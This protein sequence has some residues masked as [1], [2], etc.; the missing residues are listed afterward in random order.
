ML[1]PCHTLC[2]K[3]M[4]AVCG[5]PRAQ[6]VLPQRQIY[7]PL[8]LA[9]PSFGFVCLHGL[10]Y[11]TGEKLTT[12]QLTTGVSFNGTPA[13]FTVVSDTYIQ[14]QVPIR[15]NVREDRGHNTQRD[16]QQQHGISDFA[17]ELRYS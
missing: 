4:R 8:F 3:C 16:A 12:R 6:S 5:W 11:L 13:S 15:R 1:E 14:A 9:M 10:V 17:L 2:A 7:P